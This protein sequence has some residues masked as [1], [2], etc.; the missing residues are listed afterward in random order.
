MQD[1]R[2]FGGSRPKQTSQ[3]EQQK[4]ELETSD[5][6]KKDAKKIYIYSGLTHFF[7]RYEMMREYDVIL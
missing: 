4:I 2:E 7:D 6:N 5:G 3:L 1:K